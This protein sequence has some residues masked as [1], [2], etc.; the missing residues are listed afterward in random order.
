N[1]PLHIA[2]IQGNSDVFDEL[3][4][5]SSVDIELI[6]EKGEKPI[7]LAAQ[8]GNVHIVM[9]LLGMGASKNVRND[10]QFDPLH[11]AVRGGHLDLVRKLL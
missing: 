10:E 7:H 4:T 6:N 8:N 9:Q 11:L 2:C 3:T 1:T 5:K